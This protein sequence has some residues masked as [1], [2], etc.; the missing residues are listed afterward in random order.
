[1]VIAWM[2]F[3]RRSDAGSEWWR[4]PFHEFLIIVFGTAA[5]LLVGFA[6]AALFNRTHSK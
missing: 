6:V 3:V 4:S 1:L 5:I 2:T